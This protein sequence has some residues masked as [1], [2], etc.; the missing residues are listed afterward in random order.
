MWLGAGDKLRKA[1]KRIG[2]WQRI[3][4]ATIASGVT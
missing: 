2:D 1:L 3:F 4:E